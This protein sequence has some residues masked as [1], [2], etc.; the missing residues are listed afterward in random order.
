MIKSIDAII[1]AGGSGVRLGAEL[2]KAFVALAG[3]PMYVH[4]LLKFS[5]HPSVD[6]IIAVVPEAKVEETKEALKGLENGKEMLVVPGGKHR[7]QSVQNGV[8]ASAAEW[9]MIHDAARP[10]VSKAVID[11]VIALSG[12]YNAVI[13]T[14][15]E[16]D[17]IRKF[18]GDHALE[19]LDRS[20][21]VRVQTPQL[22]LRETL[23]SALDHA[24]FLASAPTDEAMLMETAGIPV[25][26]ASGDPLN[27]KIT[28]QE[29]LAL[30]E[31][32]CEQRG[33]QGQPKLS[34]P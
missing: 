28:T 34:R 27:F 2:P 16:V 9:V 21:V 33:R 4:S 22:F 12:R 3:K 10:F 13:A 18:I 14:T 30:A 25:G 17:T 19:T 5:A 1:V 26:I 24:P 15:P 7:W 31:A 20:S 29:D 11:A 8:N 23:L 6:R 32:L